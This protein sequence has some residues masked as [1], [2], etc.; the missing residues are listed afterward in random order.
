MK[1]GEHSGGNNKK[2]ISVLLQVIMVM[3]VV[4]FVFKLLG[5]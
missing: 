5:A 1:K 3:A 4:F 2:N